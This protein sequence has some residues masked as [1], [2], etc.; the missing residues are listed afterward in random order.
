VRGRAQR[1][2]YAKPDGAVRA[3]TAIIP[4]AT[5]TALV[6][7]VLGLWY[8]HERQGADAGPGRRP[9]PPPLTIDAWP[10]PPPLR[11]TIDVSSVAYRIGYGDVYYSAAHPYEG[12]PGMRPTDPDYNVYL[13]RPPS[14]WRDL[15]NEQIRNSNKEVEQECDPFGLEGHPHS[16]PHLGD[17][18]DWVAGEQQALQDV[19][20]SRAPWTTTTP[21]GLGGIDCD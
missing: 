9:P 20:A 19:A 7:G 18:Q 3:G 21:A 6:V 5:I 8:V 12:V 11:T 17:W 1:Q 14:E 16:P 15:A 4:L 13:R 2:E 10:R